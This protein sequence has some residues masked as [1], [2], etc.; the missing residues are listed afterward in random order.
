MYKYTCF[1]SHWIHPIGAGHCTISETRI[2]LACF[3]SS[4]FQLLTG[5]WLLLENSF[6]LYGSVGG[7]HVSLSFLALVLIFG[8][9]WR[10]PRK[11][12]F[13]I[14]LDVLPWFG[15]RLYHHH[16]NNSS[17]LRQF[18]ESTIPCYNHCYNFLDSA[19]LF[20]PVMM[21]DFFFYFSW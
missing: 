5:G 17:N 3:H 13:F 6:F 10:N 16:H 1:P 7:N 12:C 9:P 21:I 15:F 11:K 18:I 14:L 2:L 20:L 19:F 8:E 4:M